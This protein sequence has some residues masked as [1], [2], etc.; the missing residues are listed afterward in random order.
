MNHFHLKACEPWAVVTWTRYSQF[1]LVSNFLSRNLYRGRRFIELSRTYQY[2][3][4][5]TDRWEMERS[6][7]WQDSQTDRSGMETLVHFFVLVATSLDFCI[8]FACQKDE[9]E[10]DVR[11]SS[12][13]ITWQS[14]WQLNLHYYYFRLCN[15]NTC[16]NV[17]TRWYSDARI[18]AVIVWWKVWRSHMSVWLTKLPE[19]WAWYM[20]WF[21]VVLDRAT[22][23][24]SLLC[25]NHFNRKAV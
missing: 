17:N 9:F 21:T 2:S 13:K 3:S 19:L 24:L 4:D 5:R 22:F 25:G 7:S 20:D 6:S 14:R 18:L 11:W 15:D 8:A 1:F 16:S 23:S 12:L 10:K